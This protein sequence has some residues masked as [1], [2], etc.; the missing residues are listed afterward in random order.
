MLAGEIKKVLSEAGFNLHVYSFFIAESAT[1]TFLVPF[2]S[3]HNFMSKFAKR[4]IGN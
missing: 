4:K 3:C 1:G 2:V